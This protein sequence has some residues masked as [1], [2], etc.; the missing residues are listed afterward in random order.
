MVATGSDDRTVNRGREFLEHLVVE[1][2]KLRSALRIPQRVGEI[3][4]P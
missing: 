1:E 2:R 4:P 3:V